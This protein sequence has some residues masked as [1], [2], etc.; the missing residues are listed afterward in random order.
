M[1]KSAQ[2]NWTPPSYSGN[3]AVSHFTIEK[4]AD[5]DDPGQWEEVSSCCRDTQKVVFQLDSG[6]QY[7]FRVYA[8]NV[9]GKGPPSVSSEVTTRRRGSSVT[10][11]CLHYHL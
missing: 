9:I 5:G 10:G 2:L 6:E 7:Q 4:R 11:R 1:A 8:V 3:V